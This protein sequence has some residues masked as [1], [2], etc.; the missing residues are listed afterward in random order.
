MFTPDTD[1]ALQPDPFLPA[2]YCVASVRRDLGDTVTIELLPKHGARPDFTPGQ[3]NMLYIPGVGEAAISMSGHASESP[4]YL[5]T[6]RDVG[7]ISAALT[8]VATGAQIGVRGPFGAGWPMRQAE[9]RD[10]LIIAGGLGMAP[11]RPAVV[12]ILANRTRYGRVSVLAG[13]R[14]PNDILYREEVKDW[15]QRLDLDVLVTVDR[16]DV[17]WRGN[18]GVAPMLISRAAIDPGNTIAMVCGP[19][20]MMRVTADMLLHAGVPAERIYLSMERN[21][22]CAIGLCGHCQFGPGFVCKDGP[23]MRLDQI[24]HLLAVREI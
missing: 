15:R 9:G 2:L 23:V 17:D 7:A 22:K 4:G 10:V 11:L 13:S 18:V 21:M 1:V 20:V 19:E 5:H 24:A 12:G 14:N 8:H 6:I 3:F 16:A